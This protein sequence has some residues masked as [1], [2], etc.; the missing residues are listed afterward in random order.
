L[1][2]RNVIYIA[3]YSGAQT[4]EPINQLSNF[5]FFLGDRV[6]VW[7]GALASLIATA[8]FIGHLS[9]LQE[10]DL[11]KLGVLTADEAY[12]AWKSGKDRLQILY[13]M[14]AQINGRYFITSRV[15]LGD[16]EGKGTPTSVVISLPME[17]A[18]IGATNDAHSFITYYSLALEARRIGCPAAVSIELLARARDSAIDL[19][20]RI[21]NDQEV[22]R[23]F[24]DVEALIGELR[25]VVR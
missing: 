12:Q 10:K 6:E 16:L 5:L 3:R 9:M 24:G 11:T 7:R 22:K 14:V 21:P 25:K 18:A 19:Q 15:H 23:I 17:D 2:A 4:G 13:G 1:D 8:P 20:Q